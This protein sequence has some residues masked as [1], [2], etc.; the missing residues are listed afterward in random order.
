M[1]KDLAGAQ[2]DRESLVKG[3]PASRAFDEQGKATQAGEGFARSRGLEAGQ[4]QVEEIDG[5]QYVVARVFEKGQPGV[6][7]L[8][9]ALPGLIAGLRVD[10]T[11]RWN[12]SGAAFSR[13]IRWLLALF[14]KTV[15][16]FSYA[17]L[18]SGDSTRGL[19]FRDPET[20][21]VD[22]IP[23]YQAFLRSQGIVLN[24]AERSR[25]ILEQT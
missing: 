17:G 16:P 6:A 24:P 12:A 11:M 22:G 25:S 23:A 15:V 2:P 8:A 4:L 20:C 3:P 9:E 18:I 10:K 7:V 1:V 19:R 13:P 21:V 14:G 5:G